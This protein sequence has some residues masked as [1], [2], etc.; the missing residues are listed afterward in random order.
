MIKPSPQQVEAT[1]QPE[2]P[3]LTPN[4]RVSEIFYSIQG[5]GGQAGMAMIFVRLQGCKAQ[6]AC[7]AA[8]IRCDTEFESGSEFT[9]RELLAYIQQLAPDCRHI[10]WTGGEPLDQLTR[11]HTEYMNQAGYYQSLETSGLHPIL[12][13]YYFDYVTIS[14]KVAEHV[15]VKNFNQG[16]SI[17]MPNELR[18]VRHK[19]QPLPEPKIEAHAYYISPHSDG[20]TLN[21]Q[22]VKAVIAAIQSQPYVNGQK[23]DVASDNI[24]PRQWQ[25]SIQQHKLYKIL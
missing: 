9:I 23:P 13:A 16:G 2:D 8:G 5:E 25:L 20:N 10:L 22:N 7:Y 3:Y 14:P 18:Y 24:Q 4:L 19:G 1:P 12:A 11:E 15:M 17:S 6:H 21:W